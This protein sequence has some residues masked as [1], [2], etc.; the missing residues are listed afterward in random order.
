MKRTTNKLAALYYLKLDKRSLLLNPKALHFV[1]I[2]Q[3]KKYIFANLILKIFISSYLS[4]MKL[5]IVSH[6][7]LQQFTCYKNKKQSSGFLS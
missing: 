5:T 3:V 7:D 6:N 2:N 1:M 4:S